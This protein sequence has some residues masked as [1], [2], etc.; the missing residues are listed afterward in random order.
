MFWA[1]GVS[2]YSPCHLDTPPTQPVKIEKTLEKGVGKLQK[3]IAFRQ[4]QQDFL[5]GSVF[6]SERPFGPLLVNS[7]LL[8]ELLVLVLIS[9]VIIPLVFFCGLSKQL[10]AAAL[11]SHFPLSSLPLLV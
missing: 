4:S 7:L 9:I 5:E 6:Y 11:S 1:F 3:A 2:A 10:R 8:K